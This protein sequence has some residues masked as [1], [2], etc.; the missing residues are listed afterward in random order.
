MDSL[1]RIL[2]SVSMAAIVVVFTLGGIGQ[3]YWFWMSIQIGSFLMFLSGLFPL[4]FVVTSPVGAWSLF[5]GMP[6]WVYNIFG[7]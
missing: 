6:N 7:S 5:F 3:L 1:T 4:F 2:D